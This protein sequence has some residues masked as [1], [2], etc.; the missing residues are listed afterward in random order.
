MVQAEYCNSS[1]AR[2]K[3]V[4]EW[5]N[6]SRKGTSFSI[7][8]LPLL[9]LDPSTHFICLFPHSWGVIQQ[10]TSHI[11]HFL[12]H[13]PHVK[14]YSLINA[15]IYNNHNAIA[16]IIECRY[17]KHI[18]HCYLSTWLPY[19]PVLGWCQDLTM[20]VHLLLSWDV[21]LNESGSWCSGSLIPTTQTPVWS[22]IIPHLFFFLF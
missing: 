12:I 15:S 21:R 22:K 4:W 3:A 18:T 13:A 1:G 16:I 19:Q 20:L 10:A 9:L 5:S 6:R 8:S 14:K 2:A 11:F 17:N 7:P